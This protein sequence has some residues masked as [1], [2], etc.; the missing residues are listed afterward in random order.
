MTARQKP[1][2]P[3]RARRCGAGETASILAATLAALLGAGVLIATETAARPVLVLN[4]SR[5]EPLGLYARSEQTPALGSY[6]VFPAPRSVAGYAQRY[7]SRTILKRIAAGPGAFAC[8]QN[9]VLFVDGRRWAEVATKDGAG[10]L[11]P[12]W[13]GCRRLLSGEFFTFSDQAPNSLDSRYFGP[14]SQTQILGVFKPLLASPGRP[15]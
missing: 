13:N 7:F 2:G 10:R 9:H 14:V 6:V 1:Q 15:Q 8:V 11:L 12:V 3:S 5:S 4:L